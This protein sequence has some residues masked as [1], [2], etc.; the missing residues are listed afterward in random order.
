LFADGKG[1]ILN[2]E[3]ANN[4]QRRRALL[5]H[6]VDTDVQDIIYTLSDIGD[7]KDYKKVVDAL[8]TY[9]VSK[10]HTTY[11]RHCFRQLIQHLGKQFDSAT[12]QRRA[13]FLR[14]CI[15]TYI[16][17]NLLGKDQVLT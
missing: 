13:A 5:L 7:A 15:S 12:R 14:K 16:K 17:R 11:S 1:V 2:E 10:V 9:F 3:N 8:N 4:R 6:L